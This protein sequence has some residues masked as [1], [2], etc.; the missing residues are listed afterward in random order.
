M[1]N[2]VRAIRLER[3][4]YRLENVISWELVI[5]SVIMSFSLV[6]TVD[7]KLYASLLSIVLKAAAPRML[8]H[9]QNQNRRWMWMKA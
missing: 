2:G 4:K 3:R 1:A 6:D 8:E 5:Q 7:Y 9:E